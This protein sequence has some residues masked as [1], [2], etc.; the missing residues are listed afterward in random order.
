MS[1]KAARVKY[2]QNHP[3]LSFR[4]S[5]ELKQHLERHLEA[6]GISG[7]D[8]VKQSLGVA[9]QNIE[10]V[11]RKAYTKGHQDGVQSAT[12]QF[13]AQVEQIR[14]QAYAQGIHNGRQQALK[15]AIKGHEDKIIDACLQSQLETAE[16]ELVRARHAEL[17]NQ[18]EEW[19][20]R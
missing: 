13:K 11:R 5:R 6:L 12:A 8:F 1:S 18:L 20:Q 4:L 16:A 15:T 2:D 19:T 10:E 7:A 9:R 14:A 17:R 3:T